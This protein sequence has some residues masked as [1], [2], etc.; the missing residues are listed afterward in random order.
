MDK[1]LTVRGYLSE[2]FMIFGIIVLLLNVFCLLFGSDAEPVST[3]F[4]FGSEGL[5]RSTMFEF[6][7]AIALI[8][9]L[10]VVFMTDIVIKTAPI[11]LR[12]IL[13]FSGAFAVT[14]SFVFMFGWFPTSNIAAWAMFG[15]C[16]AASCA[17][18]TF[19]AFFSERQ[20]NKMLEEALKHYKE[21]Q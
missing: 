9:A 21:N 7:A 10:R 13:M 18:S 2:V 19:V 12:V 8:V 16:F 3:I 5:A 15:I 20:E 14:V 6:F 17:I 1:K 4:A 11:S